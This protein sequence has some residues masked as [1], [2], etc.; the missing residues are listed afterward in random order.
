MRPLLK[1]VGGKR[2]LAKSI[3][4]I[5]R[6]HECRRLIEPFAGSAAVFFELLPERAILHDACAPLLDFYTVV[7]S[8]P[9]EMIRAWETLLRGSYTED[10]YYRVR[11][12][13]N[14]RTKATS[15]SATAARFL[16]LNRLAFHGLWRVN[17]KGE[18]NTPFGG[19]ERPWL[20]SAEDIRTTGEVLRN[21]SL[22]D[23]WLSACVQADR[24]DFVYCD[25]PYQGTYAGYTPSNE[26]GGTQTQREL[27][28]T[29]ER[30]RRRGAVVVASNV[31]HPEIR[32]FY[33][34]RLWR[35][36]PVKTVQSIVPHNNGSGRLPE[37]LII[38]KA[39]KC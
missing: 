29:C 28:E 26:W 20:P 17:A 15:V 14:A 12:E 33:P 13:F 18:M 34:E 24:G 5:Y 23:Q 7:R 4:A 22:G 39:G 37:I 25:P 36:E 16:L 21:V 8:L 1:W 10:T 31:D 19:Y 35:I 27:A 11:A 32:K 9:K 2:R 38:G 6:A 30:M 3:A